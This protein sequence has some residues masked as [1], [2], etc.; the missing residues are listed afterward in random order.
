MD[1]VEATRHIRRNPALAALPIVAMTANAMRA[2]RERC[3]DA[4]MNGVLTKPI[5][6]VE[7]WREIVRWVQPR[8]DTAPAPAAAGAGSAT[9]PEAIAGLDLAAGLRRAGGRT[10]RYADLL[11]SFAERHADGAAHVREALAVADTAAATRH[12]HTLKGLAGTLGADALQAVARDV[13]DRLR[14]GHAVPPDL[15]DTLADTLDHQVAAIR[16][17]WPE[18]HTA[19]APTTA[20]D[21]ARVGAALD[22]LAALLA[23]DDA[24]AARCV[25]DHASLLA[26]A[27]PTRFRALQ[28]AVR[29]FDY[30]EALRLL[31]SVRADGLSRENPP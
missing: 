25:D 14:Q 15:L 11:R 7:M 3:L 2:D 13:E 24:R 19:D 1:G 8:T 5:E 12:V 23:A 10:D 6:P 31:P 18:G 29:Q 16:A 9:L 20:A 27:S 17:A 4:G 28:D 22:T 26:A 30:D 21:P